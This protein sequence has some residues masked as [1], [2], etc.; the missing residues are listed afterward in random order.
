ML[1]DSLAGRISE[2]DV[3]NGAIP[4][5]NVHANLSKMDA[6]TLHCPKND[7]TTD[8][9]TKKEFDIMKNNSFIIN[10]ARGG[11]L[12]EKDLYESLLEKNIA[13]AESTS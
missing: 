13:A 3:I 11:I 9:F 6:V 2:V 12:N 5:D 1:L 7:E 8:F 10:C 4:I